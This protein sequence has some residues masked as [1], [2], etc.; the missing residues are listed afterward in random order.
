MR[1]IGLPPHRRRAHRR[2]Y[3]FIKLPLNRRADMGVSIDDVIMTSVT[4]IS[5]V[6]IATLARYLT[7]L[8]K[9]SKK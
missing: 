8:L 3:I 7:T 6:V 1:A 4:I 9:I 2:V 5:V